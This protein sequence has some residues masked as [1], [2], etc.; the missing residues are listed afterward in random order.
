MTVANMKMF[1]ADPD[2]KLHKGYRSYPSA[3]LPARKDE[4]ET[5]EFGTPVQGEID[6]ERLS[7][8][9][10][11]KRSGVA[12]PMQGAGAGANSK[13]GIY[14]A[15]GTLS[16]LQEGNT[17]TDL[18]VTDMRYAHI[19]LGRL[20]CKEYAEFGSDSD[21]HIKRLAMF[22]VMGAKIK[23]ALEALRAGRLAIPVYASSASVN[24]EVEK[25]NDLM[26]SGAMAR[27]YQ[28]ITQMLQQAESPL[29]QSMPSMKKYLE[30]AM[31]SANIL[32]KLVMTHFGY[33]EVERIVPD[34]VPGQSMQMPGQQGSPQGQ[35]GPIPGGQ[36]QPM[37][38]SLG[39]G[40]PPIAGPAGM[41]VPTK[42][43]M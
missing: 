41:Q 35:Q 15:M 2:S 17:R 40:Q 30:D 33:D 42:G 1:R 14:T 25:Q 3:M 39:P 5:L 27:H 43:V 4:L 31:K 8:E 36:P 12:P 19:R 38:P 10:A 26:V 13:R 34:P 28:M 18:N 7:L 37:L 9:L 24:R 6:S 16:V 23:V 32:M 29:A 22:G 21:F 20:V 11:D